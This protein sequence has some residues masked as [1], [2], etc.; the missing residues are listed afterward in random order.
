M[1]LDGFDPSSGA[2]HEGIYGL[3]TSVEDA[4]V[5]IV[6][7]PFDATTS[8][9]P[10]TRNG[11]VAVYAASDQLDL[12]DIDFGRPYERGIAMLPLDGELAR[13]VL[14]HSLE[15]R[16][17][18]EPVIERGGILDGDPD[19]EAAL[20]E[21]NRRGAE[22]NALVE[23][24]VAELLDAGKMPVVLGGDHS[25][26]YGAIAAYATRHPGMGILH[27]DA[28]ADLREAYE[29][30]E[31]SHA[32]IMH[33]VVTRIGK[34][35]G[36]RRLVQ[37]GIRDFCD[38]ER[39]FIEAAPGE[40]GVEIRTHFDSPLQAEK[41]RGAPWAELA[42]RVVADLPDEVYVSFDIDGLDPRLCPDT[43]TPVPGGLDYHE[44]REL[45]RAVVAAG[46][47]IVGFDLNEVAPRRDRPPEDWGKDWNANVGAR[48]LYS[49]IGAALASQGRA[50]AGPS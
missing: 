1:S 21:V 6:P 9:Q 47:R 34:A 8:Y 25:T 29:G 31:W 3:P 15:A 41:M 17:L 27:V 7:V 26:P 49:L 46:K 4:H 37:V 44:A 11:P 43:G 42:A 28:H 48:V 33:N 38:E 50:A 36:V 22:V 5:V 2:I 13:E 24:T 20:A 45:L 12:Y 40:H 35:G 10:G 32:S 39:E 23:A 18:A 30:F 16:Q 14:R 19:L